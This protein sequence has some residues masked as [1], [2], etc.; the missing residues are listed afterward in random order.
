M[1]YTITS[2][3]SWF[4]F[5]TMVMPVIFKKLEISIISWLEIVEYGSTATQME[6]FQFG[7]TLLQLRGTQRKQQQYKFQ[8]KLPWK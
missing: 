8:L 6:F 2:L 7:M 4:L 1:L 5:C 3:S